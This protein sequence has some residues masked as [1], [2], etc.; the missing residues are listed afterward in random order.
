MGITL[1][2]PNHWPRL[3]MMRDAHPSPSLNSHILQPAPW[4][5]YLFIDSIELI[6]VS[7]QFL[8]AGQLSQSREDQFHVGHGAKYF[9]RHGQLSKLHCREVPQVV[10][11]KQTDVQEWDPEVLSING[12]PPPFSE[13]M[14]GRYLLLRYDAPHIGWQYKAIMSSWKQS[15]CVQW[16]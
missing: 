1:D 12:S 4:V 9:F 5:S 6:P 2:L 13:E 16:N 14:D 15:H 10:Q 8:K 7:R 11:L 3:P